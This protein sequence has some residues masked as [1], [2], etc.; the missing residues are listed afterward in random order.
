MGEHAHKYRVK[1]AIVPPKAGKP[2]VR[3]S[4]S[5]YILKSLLFDKYYTGHSADFEKRLSEHN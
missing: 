1:A 5:V 2:N 3:L 4:Y